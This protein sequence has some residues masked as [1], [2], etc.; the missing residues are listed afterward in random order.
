MAV[1]RFSA[2]VLRMSCPVMIWA[3]HFLAIYGF[4]AFVCARGLADLRWLGVGIVPWTITL[5]TLLAMAATIAVILPAARAA[6]ASFSHWMAATI[7]ALALIA[8]VWEALPV[9]IVPTCD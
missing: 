5:V 6:R 1:S 4:T 3:M 8:I 9:F 7:G 2:S